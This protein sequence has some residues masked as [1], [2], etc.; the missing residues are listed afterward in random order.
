VTASR[1]AAGGLDLFVAEA[2]V[3]EYALVVPREGRGD[4]R[5]AAWTMAVATA[6]IG[7]LLSAALVNQRADAPSRQSEREALV[8]RIEALSEGVVERQAAID[9]LT[10]QTDEL[11]A[12]VGGDPASE[13]AGLAAA[14]AAVPMSGAGLR[15]TLDDAPGSSQDSL[16][17]VL[18]RDLQDVV[19]A[20]WRQGATGIAINGHRLTAQTAIRS[21]GAA[22]LVDY[23]PLSP[24]YAVEAVG[25]SRDDAGPLSALLSVL[26]D[27]YGL[28]TETVAGDIALP[29]GDVRTVRVAQ[30]GSTT[31]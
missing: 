1:S 2:T 7:I 27:D 17:R 28:V 11:R 4:L 30:K 16:N 31:P 8:S 20:L 21:A 22:V 5:K 26:H 13:P 3:D 10:V 9:E 12:A 23:R 18:D 6:V 29:A 25:A 19:N 14:A 15:V 24:P